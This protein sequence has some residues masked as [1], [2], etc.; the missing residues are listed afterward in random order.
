M[1]LREREKYPLRGATQ[2]LIKKLKRNPK[3]NKI[4][5]NLINYY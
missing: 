4:T 1:G 3:F 5:I 2:N